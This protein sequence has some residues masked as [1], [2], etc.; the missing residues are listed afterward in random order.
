MDT[1]EFVSSCTNLVK[2]LEGDIEEVEFKSELSI[3]KY[4]I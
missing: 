3:L 2:H 1:N 4:I